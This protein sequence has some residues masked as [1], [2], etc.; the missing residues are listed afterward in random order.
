MSEAARIARVRKAVKD[1]RDRR[2][3]HADKEAEKKRWAQEMLQIGIDRSMAGDD[4]RE[5]GEKRT[6]SPRVESETGKRRRRGGNN[7]KGRSR[8]R[9][10]FATTSRSRA[11]V[12]PP[13]CVRLV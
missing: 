1:A 9:H 3:V 2:K 5:K 12:S 13:Q 6:G 10:G 4:E 8:R 7:C 11:A